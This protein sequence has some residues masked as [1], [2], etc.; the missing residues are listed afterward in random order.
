MSNHKEALKR[1]RIIHNILRRGG[2]HKTSRILKVCNDAGIPVKLRTIQKDLEDLAEDTQLGFFL[3]I[4]KDTATKTYYYEYI[5]NSIFP[6]LELNSEEVTALLFYAR[7]VSQYEQYPLF[8]EIS[9]AVKKV[10]ENSN[11]A[12]RV[13]ELFEKQNIL[14]TE[15]HPPIS[16]T[17]LIADILDAITTRKVLEVDYQKFDDKI[18]EHY[19]KPILLKE[20]KKFWYI[21]GKTM[22]KD[23]LITLALD[24][25]VDVR[26]TDDEF[27]EIKFNSDDHFKYSF[28]ITVEDVEPLNVTIAFN[29][30]QGNYIK[31]L[32]IHNTQK[33]IEDTD[34]TLIIQVTVKPSYEF[35]AKVLSY[36][37]KAVILS[38]DHIKQQFKDIF[39]E[40]LSRYQ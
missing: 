16:G 38:P 25:I 27:D 23:R 28:G 32:P 6:S 3:P 20:D 29:A 36:G 4:K 35:Y 2:K 40:A 17:E 12:P 22:T 7:T 39:E 37:D 10:I 31:T 8:K 11:I 33:I 18:K 15:K 19:L 5:P 21:I 1:Y 13:K 30:D 26:I 14:E 34:E 24:R 9:N